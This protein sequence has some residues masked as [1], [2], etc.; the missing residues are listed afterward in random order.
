MCHTETI[1]GQY[2]KCV[3]CCNKIYTNCIECNKSIH[4]D[5]L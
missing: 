4:P 1:K 2:K 3:F 5:C